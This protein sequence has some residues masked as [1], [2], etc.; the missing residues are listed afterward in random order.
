LRAWLI[1]TNNQIIGYNESTTEV[2]G[3]DLY[4]LT[5]FLATMT[6]GDGGAGVFLKRNP[7]QFILQDQYF[8]EAWFATQTT[9]ATTLLV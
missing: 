3:F 7:F 6:A 4:P 9:F 2:R 8:D 1:N 5:N